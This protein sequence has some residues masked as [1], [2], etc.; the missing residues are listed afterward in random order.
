MSERMKTWHKGAGQGIN[1]IPV[2]Y[3]PKCHKKHYGAYKLMNEFVDCECGYNFYAFAEKDLQILMPAHETDIDGVV[4]AMRRFV[5]ESGRCQDID[6][7]LLEHTDESPNIYA[8]ERDP[9]VEF[10][11]L[12][13]KFGIE[14]F[15]ECYVTL[16]VIN[17]IHNAFEK[18]MDVL[19]KKQ[20]DGVDMSE[21]KKP[22]RAAKPKARSGE[23]IMKYSEMLGRAQGAAII[24]PTK[25]EDKPL[26]H[27][28]S[29]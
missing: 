24:P 21:M 15:G 2:V 1:E 23:R 26:A 25:G 16:E 4:R 10:E 6:P 22:Q 12:L 17:F 20:K 7:R 14:I 5:V 11:N 9:E 29:Q 28:V 19:L 27:A 18:N 3:C 8:R 13:E